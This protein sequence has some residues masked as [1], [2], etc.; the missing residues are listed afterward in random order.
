MILAQLVTG[1]ADPEWQEKTM[2][3]GDKLT[4]EK[5]VSLLEGLEMEKAS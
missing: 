4:V 5:A 3:L 2:V 1:L